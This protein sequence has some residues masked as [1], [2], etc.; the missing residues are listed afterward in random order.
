MAVSTRFQ[1]LL[2]ALLSLLFFIS[3]VN[4]QNL[5][6]E[7]VYIPTGNGLVENSNR[8]FSIHVTPTKYFC[9]ELPLTVS[10]QI[11]N[12]L[13]VEVGGGPAFRD[14]VAEV[15]FTGDA[16]QKLSFVNENACYKNGFG[17]Q[18]GVRWLTNGDALEGFYVNPEVTFVTRDVDFPASLNGSPYLHQGNVTSYDVRLLLGYDR[19]VSSYSEHLFYGG[20]IGFG[21]RRY[22]ADYFVIDRNDPGTRRGS[23]TIPTLHLGY[24]L[25]W[26]F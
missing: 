4:A 25:G 7:E 26:K 18:A 15:L 11:S 8:D 21:M 22:E 13:V 14:R 17:V 9:G 1:L 23:E 6:S 2:P 12:A 10:K 19:A 5:A 3:T 20:F 24:R 16:L